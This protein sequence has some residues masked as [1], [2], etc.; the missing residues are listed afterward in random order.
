MIDT[1]SSDPD[2]LKYEENIA[3]ILDKAVK[4]FRKTNLTELADKWDGIL[5]TYNSKKKRSIKRQIKFN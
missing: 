4:L 5:K 1:T 2:I 3:K